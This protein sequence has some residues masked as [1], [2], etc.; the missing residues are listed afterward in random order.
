MTS[1][2]LHK[3]F[4]PIRMPTE[5]KAIQ[6]CFT[7]LGPMAPEQ[8]RAILISDTLHVSE[9]WASKALRLEM[10]TVQN[11]VLSKDV[12]LKF[13]SNGDLQVPRLF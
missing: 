8:F 3:V 7:T 9:F 11:A 2:S 10:E 6:A 5:E 13:D 1:T 4:I 12:F